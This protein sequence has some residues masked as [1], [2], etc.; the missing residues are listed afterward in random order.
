[1]EL[2]KGTMQFGYPIDSFK[3]KVYVFVDNIGALKMV[4]MQSLDQG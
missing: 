1:M 3:T 2:M 4:R